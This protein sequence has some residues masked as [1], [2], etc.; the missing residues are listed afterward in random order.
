MLDVRSLSFTVARSATRNPSSSWPPFGQPHYP[1]VSTILGRD[2][3]LHAIQ[4]ILRDCRTKPPLCRNFSVMSDLL[5]L[6]EYSRRNYELRREHNLVKTAHFL[7]SS[8]IDILSVPRS[9]DMGVTRAYSQV[10]RVFSS[11]L[12]RSPEL[13]QLI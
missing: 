13:S 5:E 8:E 4:E 7:G 2:A 11:S 12:F 3:D 1:F 9:V 10:E 6:D